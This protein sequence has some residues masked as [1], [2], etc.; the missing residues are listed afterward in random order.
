MRHAIFCSPLPNIHATLFAARQVA[1]QAG[2]EMLVEEGAL[3]TLNL[4]TPLLQQ[5]D[6]SPTLFKPLSEL[7]RCL[8]AVQDTA[9]SSIAGHKQQRQQAAR[10]LA[11][12]SFWKLRTLQP[13]GAVLACGSAAVAAHGVIGLELKPSAALAAL[14]GALLRVLS[15]SSQAAAGPA[16]GA[17]Q[18]SSPS[19]AAAAGK[20][21]AKKHVAGHKG[22][23]KAAVST[24]AAGP[25]SASVAFGAGAEQAKELV[26]LQELLLWHPQGAAWAAGLHASR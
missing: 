24:S 11:A 21:G 8:A 22:G 6:I 10:A 26:A 20:A 3:R 16:D 7:H 5:Q 19:K 25:S 9:A 2:D 12:A 15:G 4:L 23:Q 13:V 1:A 18:D 14:D 17:A